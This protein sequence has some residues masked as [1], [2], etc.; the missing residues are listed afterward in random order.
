[1]ATIWMK[2]VLTVLSGMQRDRERQVNLF[3]EVQ[4]IE[5]K[6]YDNVKRSSLNE[7]VSGY[8]RIIGLQIKNL[9]FG[10]PFSN[11]HG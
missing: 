4:Q 5:N 8:A 9:N 7:M 6:P 11:F 1:M 2:T 3:H 10:Y